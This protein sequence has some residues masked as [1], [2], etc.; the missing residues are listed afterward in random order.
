MN[1]MKRFLLALRGYRPR[2]QDDDDNTYRPWWWD[3]DEDPSLGV[4]RAEARQRAHDDL[5]EAMAKGDARPQKK[6]TI[7]TTADIGKS[8]KEGQK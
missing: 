4:I 7:I 2:V 3:D 8:K 1:I 5:M 6:L